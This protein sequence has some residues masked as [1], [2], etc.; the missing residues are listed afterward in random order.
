MKQHDH[1]QITTPD[2]QVKLGAWMILD[3][4]TGRHLLVSSVR[5]RYPTLS[6]ANNYC[7]RKNQAYG[8]VRYVP[9]LDTE[10]PRHWLILA[11]SGEVT[12]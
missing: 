6:K 10:S 8:L 9:V 7:E 5:R 11:G 2:V 1:R 4:H 12:R 3:V